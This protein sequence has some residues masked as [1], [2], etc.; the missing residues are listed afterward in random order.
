MGRRRALATWGDLPPAQVLGDGMKKPKLG[1]V[2]NS[3]FGRLSSCQNGIL[4]V[5]DAR[6]CRERS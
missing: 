2:A 5:V 1:K 3:R 6:S 4:H